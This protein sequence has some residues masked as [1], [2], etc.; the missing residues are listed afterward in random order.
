MKKWIALLL[1]A[2]LCLSLAACGSSAAGVTASNES[3][4]ANSLTETK[5]IDLY[6][7]LY[8]GTVMSLN[9]DGSLKLGE[10]KGTW[11][12][13]E[14]TLTLN[15]TYAS[16]G[17]NVESRADILDENGITIIRTQE[18]AKINGSQTIFRIRTFYPEES[19]EAARAEIVKSV[20]DTVSTDILE[21]TVK[22]AALGYYAVGASTSSTGNTTNVDE[23]CEP[24]DSGFF[25]SS[26]GRCLLCIDFVIKNTDRASID[27]DKGIISFFVNQNGETKVARGYDLNNPD[28]KIGL[29]LSRMPIS[30]NGGEFKTNNTENIIM[31][32]SE[33]YEIKYVGVVGFEPNDLTAPFEVI[34]SIDNSNGEREEFL[35][36]IQ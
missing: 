23:A 17:E 31:R 12:R 15:Y 25:T 19:I 11:T 27:T 32:E 34:V 14:N 13:E 20:G 29:V 35:Y 1:A 5:W 16:S 3:K 9:D 22:K 18:N 6:R 24:A 36:T 28:G 8:R 26:K 2:V 33:S 4:E 30:K 7:G 10:D 21:V